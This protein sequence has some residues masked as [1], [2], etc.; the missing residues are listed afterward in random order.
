MH[1]SNE[2]V[3][4][5]GLVWS[6]TAGASFGSGLPEAGTGA[7]AGKIAGGDPLCPGRRWHPAWSASATV[8]GDAHAIVDS[9]G[10]SIMGAGSNLGGRTGIY[11]GEQESAFIEPVF[12]L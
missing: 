9:D 5:A 12:W 1:F 11:V 4:V 6:S 7:D 8:C 10:T 2:A 3:D